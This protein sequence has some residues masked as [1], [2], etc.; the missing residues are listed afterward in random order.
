MNSIT[1]NSLSS[2]PRAATDR[3]TALPCWLEMN[4]WTDPSGSLN[5]SIASW[6]SMWKPKV[7]LRNRTVS[8]MYDSVFCSR[9]AI[10]EPTSVPMATRN[11]RNSSATPNSSTA[12]ALPRRQPCLARRLTPGSMA[13]DRNSEMISSTIVPPSCD[14]M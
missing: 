10:C 1:E 4:R 5:A 7:S 14:H 8:R 11:S 12:V 2:T 13:S 6:G 9:S 3:C